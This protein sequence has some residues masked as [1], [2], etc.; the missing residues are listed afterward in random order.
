MVVVLSHIT[1]T[2]QGQFLEQYVQIPI[3]V[4]FNLRMLMCCGFVAFQ[5][6][7][8]GFTSSVLPQPVS[9]ASL[10]LIKSGLGVIRVWHA[11]FILFSH[12]AISSKTY[13]IFLS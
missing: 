1:L 13:L 5:K 12:L 7:L 4:N 2:W 11:V 3:S 9:F 10:Y 6:P 8:D